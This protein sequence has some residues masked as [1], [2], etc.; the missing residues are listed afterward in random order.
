MMMMV[1]VLVVDTGDNKS[2]DGE[3]KAIL[4]SWE[5]ALRSELYNDYDDEKLL[6]LC[7]KILDDAGSVYC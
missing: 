6:V 7:S 3:T 5:W 2:S 1:A 4:V